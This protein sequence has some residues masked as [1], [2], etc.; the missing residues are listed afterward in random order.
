VKKVFVRGQCVVDGDKWLGR[1]G[2]GQYL[3]RGE[4]GRL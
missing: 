2:M 4:S 1:E 3:S